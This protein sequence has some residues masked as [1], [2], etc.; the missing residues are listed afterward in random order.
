MVFGTLVGVSVF[1]VIRS[2]LV[3][4]SAISFPL[5]SPVCEC[6]R[7]ECPF[8]SLMR[9][10]CGMRVV[11]CMQCYMSVLTVLQCV[12]MLSRGRRYIYM[13]TIVM[14]LVLLICTFDHLKFC[15]VCINGR[16]YI[17]YSECYVVSSDGDKPTP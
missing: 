3:M 16:M 13:F 4:T 7:V 2:E 1:C 5:W 14:C 9:T 17:C 10:E 15:V 8:T 11:C 12:N 6:Q